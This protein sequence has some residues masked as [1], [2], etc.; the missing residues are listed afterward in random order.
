MVSE[1]EKQPVNTAEVKKPR[2]SI[3]DCIYD[4]GEYI[5]YVI[6]SVTTSIKNAIVRFVDKNEHRF[7]AI[8]RA[9]LSGLKK[10]GTK[11]A[12]PFVRHRK[13]TKLGL[14]E[15]SRIHKEKG[16]FSAFVAVIKLFF[17]I[18]FGKRGLAYSVFN[19]ALPVV[20][21]VMLFNIVTY[22]NN[23]SY[24]IKLNVNGDFIGYIDSETTFTEA[25]RIVQQR[26]NYMESNTK[27][28][29]F[30]P[31]YQLETVDYGSTLT[32]YQLADKL[33]TSMGAEIEHAYGM[34]IGNSFYGA[35]VEKDKVEATLD[36]LLD[37]YRTGAEN[38]NVA[39]ELPITYEPGLYLSE[40]IVTEESII[41]I[42]TEKRTTAAYYTVVDGDSPLGI[43]SKLDISMDE[44][45]RLNPGFTTNMMYVGDEILITQEEPFLAVTVTR[46]EVYLENTPYET[47]YVND[48]SRYEGS[49]VVTQDG[50]YGTDRVT[51]DVSYINGIETRRKVL[52]RVTVSDPTTKIVAIGT[53][54]HPTDLPVSIQPEVELGQMYW[55]V[56]GPTGGE[57][58]EMMYGYGGYYGHDGIDIR[59]PYGTPIIAAESGVV[60]HS[61]WL[62]GYGYCIKI[63]HD[64]GIETV[65]G[66]ASYL[67]VNVG[68]KVTQG[69]QIADVGSTGY[70]TGNHLH[71]EV[72]IN[73]FC[74]NPI[75]YLPKHAISPWCV[76][77]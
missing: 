44:L 14:S 24:A 12:S 54:P 43:S 42:I 18:L 77:W 13:A 67:H 47:S 21:M 75:N 27:T 73:G 35:L 37:V 28:V 19:Y 63:K 74:M 8:G 56:G 53:K 7:A 55:P 48:S 60:T 58:S 22:A 20:S 62:G 72:R 65:Y 41:D 45:E 36:G 25:E 2:K 23:M 46:T 51:A 50:V 57:I 76:V 71:F 64:N 10:I 68:E 6:I 40:S 1:K 39:F 17:R 31:T 69:Q 16:F 9:L 32:K 5:F 15:I 49:S 29:T 66:H 34:Y 30:E 59:A 11:I 70:S 61:G 4:L 38:E 33:L 26:I 3:Y 52:D